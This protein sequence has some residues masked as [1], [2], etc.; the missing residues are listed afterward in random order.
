MLTSVI[1]FFVVATLTLT[2]RCTVHDPKPRA[3]EKR[4]YFG[5]ESNSRIW[6][7]LKAPTEGDQR[8]W[9]SAITVAVQRYVRTSLPIRMAYR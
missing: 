1:I 9:V 3:K 2:F 6:M 5:I 7:H 4:L 8:N